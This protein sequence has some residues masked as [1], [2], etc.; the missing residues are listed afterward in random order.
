M[1]EPVTGGNDYDLHRQLSTVNDATPISYCTSNSDSSSITPSPSPFSVT[2]DWN[3]H[4]MSPES[5]WI[6]T[7]FS[8]PE[9]WFVEKKAR[10]SGNTIDKYYHDPETGRKFRSLKDVERYL[11]EGL[12]PTRSKDKN[13]RLKIASNGKMQDFEEDK[14]NQYQLINVTTSPFKLPDGWIVEE[15][16]RKTGDRI[17]RYY[18]EPRTGHKFRSL[19]SVQKH[20]A[21]LEENSPLSV[22]LEELRENNLPLSKAFKLATPI[23]NYGSYDSWKKSISKSKQDSSFSI[24]NA[25]PNKINWVI[26]STAGATWNAFVADELVPDSMKQQWGRRFMLTV[27]NTKHDEQG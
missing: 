18:Y 2:H 24:S 22:I 11:T 15:V 23:K 27:N 8:L 13:N 25:P 21:E 9:D 10:G 6:T 1:A 20:L 12:L 5:K 26:S 7:K 3:I 16:P 19:Q 14:D 17:D 4:Q